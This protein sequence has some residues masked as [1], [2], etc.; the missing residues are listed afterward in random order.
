MLRRITR[1]ALPVLVL[2]AC[3]DSAPLSPEPETRVY[4]V[5]MADEQTLPATHECPAPEPDMVTGT[6]FVEGDLTLFAEGAFRWRY[7]IEHYVTS[8]GEE[9]TAVER[10]S[11]VGSYSVSGD[12]LQLEPSRPGLATRTGR[13]LPGGVELTEAMSCHF[14]A[15]GEAVHQTDLYLTRR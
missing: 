5:V 15:S 11:L 8:A 2:V 12:R 10:V 7:T 4:A 6:R 3:G 1:T 13:I 9:Q 14:P